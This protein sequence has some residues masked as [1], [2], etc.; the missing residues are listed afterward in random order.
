M[1]RMKEEYMRQ[2]Y[3]SGMPV[4]H[5]PVF[6]PTQYTPES[7][8]LI[9]PNCMDDYLVE[10]EE[11]LQCRECGRTYALVGKQEVVEKEPDDDIMK[12]VIKDEHI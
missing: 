2:L 9:C 11:D 7:T 12:W 1:S 3:E 8:N 10:Q 4:Q 6:T 5:M